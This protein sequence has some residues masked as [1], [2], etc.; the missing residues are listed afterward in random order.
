MSLDNRNPFAAWGYDMSLTYKPSENENFNQT[1]T[2]PISELENIDD[3]YN[4]TASVAPF[5]RTATEVFFRNDENMEEVELQTPAYGYNKD[6]QITFGGE[7][8][9]SND[10]TEGGDDENT[11]GENSN[12]TPENENGNGTPENENGNDEI[13]EDE[14]PTEG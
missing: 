5:N 13:P 7:V 2:T 3:L 11:D 14:N 8:V 4:E 9:E 1:F 10:T 12:G 6:L